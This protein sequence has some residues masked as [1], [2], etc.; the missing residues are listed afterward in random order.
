MIDWEYRGN[1]CSHMFLLSVYADFL[2]FLGSNNSDGNHHKDTIRE[3]WNIKFPR[4]GS[5]GAKLS[6]V[7]NFVTRAGADIHYV[8][9]TRKKS[10]A[11]ALTLFFVHGWP[12]SY[13]AWHNF[14]C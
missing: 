10:N 11:H 13:Y 2:K 7:H 9:V 1:K 3:L 6:I 14:P 8:E 4:I 5:T 12:Q